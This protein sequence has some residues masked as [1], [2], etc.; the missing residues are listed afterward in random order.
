MSALS[1]CCWVP[2][3]LQPGAK[4]GSKRSSFQSSPRSSK[5]QKKEGSSASSPTDMELDSGRS[6]LRV[7]L[8]CMGQAAW[9][10]FIS[11]LGGRAAPHWSAQSRDRPGGRAAQAERAS[12]EA[13]TEST[14]LVAALLEASGP[15][16]AADTMSARL[17]SCISQFYTEILLHCVGGK[18]KKLWPT[19]RCGIAGKAAASSAGIPSQVRTGSYPSCSTADPVP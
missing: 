6:L 12:W 10:I 2:F 11:L 17:L 19:A 3:L 4:S 9:E 5:K 15:I 8:C 16:T 18:K 13:H 7:W 1:N 14:V